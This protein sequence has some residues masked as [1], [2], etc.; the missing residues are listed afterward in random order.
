MYSFAF[1]FWNFVGYE[2]HKK[3]KVPFKMPKMEKYISKST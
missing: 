1:L 2:L 3:A